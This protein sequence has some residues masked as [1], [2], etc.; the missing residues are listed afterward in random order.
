LLVAFHTLRSGS[1]ARA[2]ASA[3]LDALVGAEHVE[4]GEVVVTGWEAL[5]HGTGDRVD[6]DCDLVVL[7][8]FRL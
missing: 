3:T 8:D 4:Q 7:V 6:Y 5:R 1:E 2:D